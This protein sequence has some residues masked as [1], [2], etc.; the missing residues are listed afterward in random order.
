MA[1]S[2]FPLS[3]LIF[4]PGLPAPGPALLK[5]LFIKAAGIIF[6]KNHKSDLVTSLLKAFQWLLTFHFMK[7]QL[8]SS[9]M[10][11]HFVQEP[12]EEL[13][14]PPAL[15]LTDLWGLPRPLPRRDRL[16]EEWGS[17]EGEGAGEKFPCFRGERHRKP[18]SL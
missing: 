4:L 12:R 13:A 17:H 3:C 16:N 5:S 15:G 14:P 7:T 2:C 1:L 9:L 6:K 10:D 18:R 8:M 11:P